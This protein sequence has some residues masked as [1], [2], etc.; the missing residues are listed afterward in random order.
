MQLSKKTE[1]ETQAVQNTEL[2]SERIQEL[3]HQIRALSTAKTILED[4]L[5]AAELSFQQQKAEIDT[6]QEKL[7]SFETDSRRETE[8]YRFREE[9]TEKELLILRKEREDLHDKYKSIEGTWNSRS[10]FI[11][12]SNV[13]KI[14]HSDSMRKLF[15]LSMI[16]NLIAV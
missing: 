14:S 3:E 15:V 5:K 1:L 13:S 11:G 16:Q 7:K 12:E 9:Q 10:R 6:M 2:N 8:E 4:Q